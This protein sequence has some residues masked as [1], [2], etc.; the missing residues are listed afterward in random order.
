M[1]VMPDA[2]APGFFDVTADCKTMAW[3][4][5]NFPEGKSKYPGGVRDV[6][7]VPPG[8]QNKSLDVLLPFAVAKKQTLSSFLAAVRS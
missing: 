5:L 3:E 7:A 1:V 4:I 2:P 6:L 8:L